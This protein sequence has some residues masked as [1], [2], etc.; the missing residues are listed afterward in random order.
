MPIQYLIDTREKLPYPLTPAKP[1]ALPAGDYSV[2]GYAGIDGPAGITIERKSLMDLHMCCGRDHER[3]L[4]QLRR[5]AEFNRAFVVVESDPSTILAI[6][7]ED[8]KGLTGR[9]ILKQVCSF[10]ISLGIRFMF[11]SNRRMA[12]QMTRGLLDAFYRSS[13]RQELDQHWE[14]YHAAK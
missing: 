4:G 6:Y 13:Y 14:A 11:A 5:L 8:V 3:F 9:T 2:E 12:A 7:P 10:S 1:V